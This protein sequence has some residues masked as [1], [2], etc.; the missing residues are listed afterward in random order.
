MLDFCDAASAISRGWDPATY[1]SFGAV[2]S[3]GMLAGLD[4]EQMR[5]ALAM[6][7]VTAPVL[8]GR[9]GKV[10]GWK[11]LACAVAVRQALFNVMLARN[12]VSGPEPVFAGSSGFEKVVSGALELQLDAGRDRSGDSHLKLWPAIYHAQGPV[13]MCLAVHGELQADGAPEISEAQ[14]TIYDFALRFAADTPDKWSPANLE[15]ADHSLPFIAAHCLMRGEFGLGSLRSSLHDAKVRALAA[16]MRIAAGE[17]FSA[18]WPR[19]TA[20]RLRVAA[21]GKVYEKEIRFIRGHDARPLGLDDVGAKFL[22]A[23]DHAG[24]SR[25]SARQLLDRILNIGSA[26]DVASAGLMDEITSPGA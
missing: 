1:V 6:T 17:E 16:Q 26:Q 10:T 21:G 9:T 13:E 23:A 11:G 3:M 2:T 20:S 4:R 12:G 14:I 15:T 22:H 24:C 18:H 25:Q 8:L 5:Q 7:A 19:Q